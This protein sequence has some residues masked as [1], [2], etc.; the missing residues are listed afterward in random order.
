MEIQRIK[1]EGGYF[2]LN[3]LDR[4]LEKYIG[5]DK[6][7]Y[8]EL[9]ANDGVN[10]SNTYH[11]ELERG[12]SGVLIEPSP[13]NYLACK[14]RR[15]DMN[16]VYCNAC[17]PF[18]YKDRFVEMSYANLMTVSEQLE[19]DLSDKTDHLERGREFLPEKQDVFQ[20]GALA[21][22]LTSL[23]ERANAPNLIDLLS[24]DVE[25]AELDVLKG[26]DWSKFRF[27]YVLVECR[28]LGRMEEFLSQ[29]G[30]SLAE[31]LSEHDY[32]F[33]LE[34]ELFSKG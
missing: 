7:Y 21:A 24:L 28:D 20:F 25:G 18:D 6:G 9:G 11:F 1:S 17:V 2:A 26:V 10:Q 15:G 19:T 8:V 3:D 34:A 13:H 29:H 22:T 12:W 30:Y 16:H 33:G 31:K 5:Y 4:K 27:K 32:L 23:L 14:A